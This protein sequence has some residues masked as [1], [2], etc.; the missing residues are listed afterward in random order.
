MPSDS[1]PTSPQ[2]PIESLLTFVNPRREEYN[3]LIKVAERFRN[4]LG[5][6]LSTTGEGGVYAS[7]WLDSRIVGEKAIEVLKS[8]L[9]GKPLF[10]LGGGSLSVMN[11]FTQ[12]CEGTT[13]YNIERYFHD[14]VPV[15]ENSIRCG[16]SIDPTRVIR[17]DMLDFVSKLKPLS[18]NF[19]INGIDSFWIPDKRYH[20]A[21]AREL[22]RVT[23][24]GNIVFGNSAET[25][26]LLLKYGFVKLDQSVVDRY[27]DLEDQ[28]IFLK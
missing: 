23:Q 7:S 26:P 24:V 4:G 21:L 8:Y 9:A 11:R 28:G 13:Y 16:S 20:E 15:S 25:L 3:E 17:M 18:A 12:S 19:T 22:G 6:R 2:Q 1:W 10:D 14:S 27:L 5:R